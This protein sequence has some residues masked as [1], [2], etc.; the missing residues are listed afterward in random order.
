MPASGVSSSAVARG[1]GR[2]LV[3]VVPRERALAQGSWHGLKL[4]GVS[5]LL[6]LIEECGEFRPRSEVE[7][8]P[9][10]Q[11][12]IPHLV[13]RDGTK[14]LT[15]RRLRAGSEPRLRGQVTLGVGGH[16]N[17][18]DGAPRS[19]WG[20]GCRREWGEEV[21][22]DRE[23]MAQAVGLLKDDAG[24]VGQVHLGVLILVDATTAAVEV[25]ERDKLEGRMAPI[26]QL[27]VYY[28]EMETWSQFVYDALLQGSLDGAVE[29]LPMTLPRS[30]L[31]VTGD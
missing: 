14:I 12:V 22:C 9:D 27:G 8:Q 21:V 17:A 1:A 13:V 28:L 15:M 6:Q 18:G 24:A 7:A 25:R 11:Q 19:A 23:L 10:W 4:G 2:E 29:G 16:I 30:S 20:A 5:E 3:L 31:D 26:D